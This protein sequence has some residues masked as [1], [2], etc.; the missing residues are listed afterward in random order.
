MSEQAVAARRRALF[1]GGGAVQA[2]APKPARRAQTTTR[3]APVQQ[4]KP[5]AL[6]GLDQPVLGDGNA[7]IGSQGSA[8]ELLEVPNSRARRMIRPPAG[9]SASRPSLGLD[10]SG[11]SNAP[12][13][14]PPTGPDA[15][16]NQIQELHQNNRLVRP[17]T[18]N[19]RK[20]PRG[21]PFD[22]P[23]DDGG[24]LD[25]LA[26]SQHAQSNAGSHISGAGVAASATAH[27]RLGSQGGRRDQLGATGSHAD[28]DRA[29]EDLD[30]DAELGAGDEYE[31][32]DGEGGS[33]SDADGGGYQPTL[34]AKSSQARPKK[35]KK[36]KAQGGQRSPGKAAGIAASNLDLAGS[37]GKG[38]TIGSGNS[39]LG[40]Q[41]GS[42]QQRG[43]PP[44]QTPQAA[45]L[46]A[47]LHSR[48]ASRAKARPTDPRG[49]LEYDIEQER[50]KIQQMEQRYRSELEQIRIEHAVSASEL[51]T[52]HKQQRQLHEEERQRLLADKNDALE[53]EKKKL[54]QLQQIDIDGRELL[55]TKNLDNQRAVFEDQQQN[56]RRQ[57]QERREI[58]DLAKEISESS[59]SINT[60]VAQIATAN[61]GELQRREAEIVRREKILAEK[62]Q[63]VTEKRRALE[64]RREKLRQEI[65]E[66]KQ[67]ENETRLDYQRAKA[68]L[69]A[70]LDRCELEH[71]QDKRV[72][73]DKVVEAEVEARRVQLECE[74]VSAQIAKAEED[75]QGKLEEWEVEKERTR[76][77]QEKFKVE[78]NTQQRELTEKLR[79]VQAA[80]KLQNKDEQEF[81]R[82]Q[83]EFD[84]EHNKVVAQNDAL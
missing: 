16:V 46:Q 60:L 35:K 77:A 3:Q 40:A 76:R 58:K 36:R 56:L 34:I 21:G 38:N 5:A 49:A 43:R 48:D 51:E 42:W 50:E 19:V 74:R 57:L 66:I 52:K 37:A 72:V 54:A 25:L 62:R 33:D 70:E 31:S 55:Y 75:H 11:T 41:D 65:E 13:L 22:G 17:D 26:E 67:R 81:E 2:D 69:A 44:A 64:S 15:G 12:S 18:G 6:L 84:E 73:K 8:I 10:A 59:G 78:S 71:L 68:D 39:A 20:P 30:L 83:A 80:M 61:Q 14:R 45:G 23:G 32:P 79:G 1:G 47:D 63:T 24:T 27:T 7:S 53:E 9:T 29:E 4:E 82:R 28:F